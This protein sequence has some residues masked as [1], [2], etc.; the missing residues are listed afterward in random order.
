MSQN[1]NFVTMEI[2]DEDDYFESETTSV[3]EQEIM[4]SV[5]DNN[6][7]EHD[8]DDKGKHI[9]VGLPSVYIIFL[10]EECDNC[11]EKANLYCEDCSIYLCSQCSNLRHK[12]KRK[13]HQ[14][15]KL[16]HTEDLQG[17]ECD[18]Y[19]LLF[20]II[21][22]SQASDLDH[23]STVI[24]G[25]AVQYFQLLTIHSWQKKVI[26]AAINNRDTLV[27]QPT[28]SGKSLCYVIPPLYRASTAVIIS[29]TISLMM[30][31]VTKL[32]NRGIKATFL[33]SAQKE[34]I[35]QLDQFRLVFTT[36]ESF[37]DSASK[38][39]HERFLQL[40]RE[41]KLCLVAIDEGH[42]ICSWKSFR[43]GTNNATNKSCNV[44]L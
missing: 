12:S 21:V 18:Y 3:T 5:D 37:F 23:E 44:K 13:G 7:E 41:R 42:L 6:V 33:G 39:P 25:L 27:I 32:N 4:K 2:S 43:Y 1:Q 36:P 31:Q 8:S 30:D 16:G 10:I 35:N 9:L 17:E 28:G 20:E 34:I 40:A 14:V 19:S 22:V 24:C 15:K 29:P 26:S 11:C 38:R